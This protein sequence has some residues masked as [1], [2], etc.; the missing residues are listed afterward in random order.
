MAT[1]TIED[2]VLPHLSKEA[3]EAILE[4]MRKARLEQ[5]DIKR[6]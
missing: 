6:A 4:A 3:N 1:I 2:L 5:E